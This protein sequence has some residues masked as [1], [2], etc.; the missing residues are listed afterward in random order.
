MRNICIKLVLDIKISPGAMFLSSLS[1]VFAGEYFSLFFRLFQLFY[2]INV[3]KIIFSPRFF[4]F[5]VFVF[6]CP[7]FPQSGVYSS[8]EIGFIFKKI[9]QLFSNSLFL[10]RHRPKM[11]FG[12]TTPVDSDRKCKFQRFCPARS[13]CNNVAQGILSCYKLGAVYMEVGNP[14]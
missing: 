4:F 1:P 3:A 11:I 2:S 8:S 7:S 5:Q 6:L 14:R 9:V 12:Q 13:D 10:R